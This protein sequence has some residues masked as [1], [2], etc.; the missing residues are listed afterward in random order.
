MSW[1]AIR[2][3]FSAIGCVIVLGCSSGP[4][5]ISIPIVDSSAAASAAIELADKNSDQKIS[6]E[7]AIATPSLL[8][9]FDKYDGNKD[10]NIDS[11][12]IESRIASWTERGAKVIPVALGV[13]LDGQ[14][15][16]DAKVVLEPEPFTGGVLAP[17]EGMTS[18][19]GVCGPTVSR[20]LLTKEV[21][22][23]VFYGLYRVKVTHPSKTIPA[24]YNEN[25]ELGMEVAADYDFYSRKTL[26][27]S[28]K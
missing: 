11:L 17:A 13:K 6:K 16:A 18:S 22:V 20:E 21:P 23:G 14:P 24:K 2:L 9:A 19:G 10:G 5:T 8:A 7:E 28:S 4:A 27:L 1:K 12:E 15:L 25:T 3:T 26:E